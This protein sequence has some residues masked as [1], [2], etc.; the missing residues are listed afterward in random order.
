MFSESRTWKLSI[1]RLSLSITLIFLSSAFACAQTTN[2]SGIINQYTPVTALDNPACG[3]DPACK[4]E[5]TVVSTSAFSVGDRALII[6]MKG[7]TINTTNTAAGGD[8]TA[9]NNAGNYEFFVI[10][11]I[12]GNI[13]V[14]KFPL[15]RDYTPGVGV[16]QV[17]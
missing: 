6:Q 12:V 17:V 3:C 1:F 5:I 13:L 9:I 8:V 14:P 10:G 2:I 15:I 4:H 7:A 16:V 11:D